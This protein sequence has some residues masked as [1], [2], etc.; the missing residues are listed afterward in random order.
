VEA[1]IK[2]LRQVLVVAADFE[3]QCAFFETALGMK[4]KFRDENE[5]AQFDAGDVS[6]A[7]AGPREA[8]GAAPGTNVPV[9]E[10]GDL[11]A[12]LDAVVAGG[13]SH[14]TVRDMGAHGRTVLARDPVGAVLAALQKA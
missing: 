3:K 6:L 14:G 13:G 11:G 4:Q 7:L 2:R 5:W 8:L 12:F 1:G 9:F 10:V